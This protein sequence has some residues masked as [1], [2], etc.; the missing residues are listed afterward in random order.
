[1]KGVGILERGNGSFILRNLFLLSRSMSLTCTEFGNKARPSWASYIE[2]KRKVRGES[3]AYCRVLK[4]VGLGK[5]N[6][7][8]GDTPTGHC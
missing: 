2:K 6:I 3:K 4:A 5:Q 1:M 8:S 7:M